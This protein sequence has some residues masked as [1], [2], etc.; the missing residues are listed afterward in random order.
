M[1]KLLDAIDILKGFD[2]QCYGMSDP[3]DE[4]VEFGATIDECLEVVLDAAW[5]YD[6]LSS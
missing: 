3:E 5:K 4:E 2:F 6:E 1:V